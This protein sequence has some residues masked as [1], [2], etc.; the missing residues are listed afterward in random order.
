MVFSAPEL[1]YYNQKLKDLLV[2]LDT[3][4]EPMKVYLQRRV[5]LPGLDSLINACKEYNLYLIN[6]DDLFNKTTSNETLNRVNEKLENVLKKI[7]KDENLWMAVKD[8]ES[9]LERLPIKLENMKRLNR[10]IDKLLIIDTKKLVN[11][12]PN[13]SNNVDTNSISE[14]ELKDYNQK[15]NDLLEILDKGPEPIKNF[16]PTHDAINEVLVKIEEY[17]EIFERINIGEMTIEENFPTL[18]KIV[19]EVLDLLRENYGIWWAVKNYKNELLRMPK[20]IQNMEIISQEMRNLLK[21][22]VEEE[23]PDEPMDT[24][25]NEVLKSITF[26]VDPKT[27]DT[28]GSITFRKDSNQNVS[29]GKKL[30]K[31]KRRI[32]RK[33]QTKRR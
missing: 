29:G 1:I 33:R 20:Q 23:E 19:V 16:V 30:R 25:R 18:Q 31:T 21:I 11:F 6:V 4:P 17:I 3:G 22:D 12:S 32:S 24:V 8:Y 7:K 5:G 15:F 13:K 2:I 26:N 14:Q 27:M 28:V 10:K 9:E